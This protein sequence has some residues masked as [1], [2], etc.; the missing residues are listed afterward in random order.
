MDDWLVCSELVTLPFQV[1]LI[2]PTPQGRCLLFSLATPGS[3][4]FSLLI[5]K[6]KGYASLWKRHTQSCSV[7]VLTPATDEQ[8]DSPTARLQRILNETGKRRKRRQDGRE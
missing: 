6:V 4:S 8:E 5:E 3:L 7:T 2:L 1:E